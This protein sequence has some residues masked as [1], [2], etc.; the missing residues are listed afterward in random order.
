[1]KIALPVLL[2]LACLAAAEAGNALGPWQTLKNCHW[3]EHGGND[4]DSFH[5]RHGGQEFIFR[6]HYVD[7]PELKEMKLTERTTEQ[8]KYFNIYK[9]DLYLVSPRAEAFIK[10]KLSVPFQVQT[11]WE[12][13]QGQ[14]ARPRYYAIITVRGSD[15]AEL[16]VESGLARIN[17]YPSPHPDG[18][19]GQE[20]KAALKKLEAKAREAKKGAWAYSKTAK[21]KK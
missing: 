8:A 3:V 14:S 2:G 4:G 20:V 13:A 19:S 21:T 18:R 5:V 7:A 9:R 12:D 6:L 1:M 16:L 11:R 10:E 17:G 15:L